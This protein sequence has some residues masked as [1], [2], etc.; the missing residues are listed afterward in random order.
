[1]FARG[2]DT[3]PTIFTLFGREFPPDDVKA[4]W[5]L[6]P[7]T[8]IV[9]WAGEFG[10]FFIRPILPPYGDEQPTVRQQIFGADAFKLEVWMKAISELCDG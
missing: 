2:D 8:L 5:S 3:P 6:V 1:L 9:E 4:F 10:V 7:K